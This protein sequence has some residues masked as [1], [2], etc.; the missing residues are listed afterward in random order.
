MLIALAVVLG[1]LAASVYFVVLY[2]R[3]RGER[4][5]LTEY[6]QFLLLNTESYQDHRRKFLDYLEGT[7]QKTPAERGKDAQRVVETMAV[8]LFSKALP[9]NIAARNAI[10]SAAS[11]PLTP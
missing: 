6:A 9:G 3:E 11:R 7:G 2:R 5:A 1:L 10:V 8:S 4:L